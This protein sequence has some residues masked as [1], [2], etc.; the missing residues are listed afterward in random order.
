MK[1]DDLQDPKG[2]AKDYSEKGRW[3]PD[4]TFKLNTLEKLPY[5]MG[6]IR[7]SLERQLGD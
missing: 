5:A 1:I 4:V 3:N 7:Q 6:L 2:N